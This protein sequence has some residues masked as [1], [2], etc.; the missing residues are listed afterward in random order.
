MELEVPRLGIRIP[1]LGIPQDADSWDVSWLWDQAGWL[2]GTAFPTMN[3]NS[4]LTSHV[5]NANGLPG[6]FVD[7]KNLRW[8]DEIIIHAFGNRY[9]YQVNMNRYALPHH[10]SVLADSEYPMLTLITCSGY[11]ETL[12]AYRFRVVVQAVLV[13]I[14]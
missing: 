2:E 14:D 7:L 3:G 9:V 13:E 12:D 10:S 1:I 6:P 8:G 4:V 5:Y 11:N